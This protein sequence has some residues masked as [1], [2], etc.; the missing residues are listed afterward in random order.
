MS[1]P[2]AD[3]AVA[4]GG[5]G[6]GLGQSGLRSAMIS[7]YG[8]RLRRNIE[9]VWRS[10][11]FYALTLRGQHSDML[12]VR[13]VDLWAG[14]IEVAN[15]LFTGHYHLGGEEIECEGLPP[16]DAM[17]QGGTAW[18]QDLHGFGWLRH[19][20]AADDAAEAYPASA[21]TAARAHARSLVAN[22]LGSCAR[23]DPII[24][25]AEV[26]ARRLI[27][28]S[29]HL[30]LIAEQA[31]PVYRSAVFGSLARQ[32]RHLARIAHKAPEGYPRLVSA[33]GFAHI[34]LV[35][36]R[37][38]RRA[39]TAIALVEKEVQ[40]QIRADGSHIC[41]NP[42]IQLLALADLAGLARL[43]TSAG[44]EMPETMQH[45]IDRM[46]PFARLLKL[47]DGGCVN[48]HGATMNGFGPEGSIA[49]S[50][51]EPF[52]T[53][54]DIV[55][56]TGLK[57]RAARYAPYGGFAKAEA[58]RTQLVVD[59]S[60]PPQTPAGAGAH[61]STGA[62]E[63][64]A[65]RHR[66]VMNCGPAFGQSKGWQQAARTS[67]A[68]SMAVV[69]DRS[70]MTFH[71]P[72]SRV[73]Q[74]I[75]SVRDNGPDTVS[76]SRDE[77]DGATLIDVSHDGWRADFGLSHR[78]SLYLDSTGGDLRGEDVFEGDGSAQGVPLTI[79]FHLNP[80]LAVSTTGGGS[81]VLI[82][83]P[84]GPGWSFKARG[85][86]IQLE[87]TMLFIDNGKPR[88]A[89]QIVLR[90]TCG[91]SGATLKWAF[92]RFDPPKKPKDEDAD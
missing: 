2:P 86:D 8:Q 76:L 42:T 38:A 59:G 44:Q 37:N 60:L 75:G 12:D 45:A 57:A 46:V 84:T 30:P 89:R 39:R 22:W 29:N 34:S 62:F 13:P 58:K 33:I 78:R 31:E 66:L 28:W 90:G 47:G 54:D 51:A 43:I 16:W 32:T 74:L 55:K 85:G 21:P 18:Q 69:D 61:A 20:T 56:A 50:M 11:P 4:G 64:S 49:R 73:G 41:A 83:P 7:A 23:Y 63:L 91:P 25:S 88:Q 6:Y 70:L 68:H 14:D 36:D 52:A 92:R 27:S 87:D 81:T 40:S 26:T 35:L 67:A 79:R 5:Q 77:I 10:S 53:I 80:S 3:N 72:G 17:Q 1:A 19:F 15:R 9:G 48:L 71:D 24:W 82:N 65:G